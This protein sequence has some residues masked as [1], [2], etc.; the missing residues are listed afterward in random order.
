MGKGT[1]DRSELL[2]Q[3]KADGVIP[4]VMALSR[5]R[6][7]SNTAVFEFEQAVC[8]LSVRDNRTDVVT[9][10]GCQYQLFPPGPEEIAPL[11]YPELF[12][13]FYEQLVIPGNN[14]GVGPSESLK[15]LRLIE[16]AYEKAQAIQGGF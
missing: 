11:S 2:L 10:R 12:D 7:L 8:T 15:S 13:M 5:N 3:M 9:K 14:E 16:V 4:V 6:N 1:V